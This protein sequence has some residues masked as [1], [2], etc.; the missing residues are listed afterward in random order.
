MHIEGILIIAASWLSFFQPCSKL[1]LR[2]CFSSSIG[3]LYFGHVRI[4]VCHMKHGYKQPMVLSVSDPGP[5]LSWRLDTLPQ[6]E[7]EDA[8]DHDQA[9]G[10][11]PAREAQV[12]DTS[13][14]MKMQ[15]TPPA[16]GHSQTRGEIKLLLLFVFFCYLTTVRGDLCHQGHPHVSWRAETRQRSRSPPSRR[17]TEKYV[18]KM[19]TAK[20]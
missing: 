4:L 3:K 12:M 9:Q 6:A 7:V 20:K 1:N 13:T 14:L 19:F 8:D 2:S 10:Q 18:V 5:H 15:H 16:E 11:V 17:L